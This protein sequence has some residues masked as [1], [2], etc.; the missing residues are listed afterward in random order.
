MFPVREGLIE[1]RVLRANK[2]DAVLRGSTFKCPVCVFTGAWQRAPQGNR[3]WMTVISLMTVQLDQW[4]SNAPGT[5]KNYSYAVRRLERWGKMTGLPHK[6]VELDASKRVGLPED[7]VWLSAALVEMCG[8]FQYAKSMRA[9]TWNA[10]MGAGVSQQEIPTGQW[11]FTCRASGAERRLGNTNTPDAVLRPSQL[12][13]LCDLFELE[14]QNAQ[15]RVDKLEAAR[16]GC[17]F[18]IC[19]QAGLRANE[20]LGMTLGEVEA[21][22]CFG[23]VARD[24]EEREHFWITIKVDGESTT[25]TEKTKAS[26]VPVAAKAMKAPLNSGRWIKRLMHELRAVDG[27]DQSLLLWCDQEGRRWKNWFQD[28]VVPRLALL[29]V[30]KVAGLDAVDLDDYGPNTCRR[31]WATLAASTAYG[32]PRVDP[33]LIDRQARWRDAMST[34]QKVGK[35]MRNHYADPAVADLLLATFHL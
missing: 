1:N 17:I 21:H 10:Y 28:I 5:V 18:T 3:D 7:H 4:R 25:K 23:R 31:T 22:T 12:K 8:S 35:A 11:Q 24:M 13:A 33:D 16:H 15:T 32:A 29:A 27:P 34:A 19:T 2:Y 14:Y 6:M 30:R 20:P 26:M 9:A